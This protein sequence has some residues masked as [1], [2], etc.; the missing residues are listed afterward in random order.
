M[1]EKLKL[2]L[3]SLLVRLKGLFGRKHKAQDVSDVASEKGEGLQS[4]TLKAEDVTAAQIPLW[5]RYVKWYVVAVVVIVVLVLGFVLFSGGAK[6][7]KTESAKLVDHGLLLQAQ[8]ETKELKGR[9]KKLY[10]SSKGQK[11]EHEALLKSKEEAEVKAKAALEAFKEHK[12]A[13]ESQRV[14]V[15]LMPLGANT[16]E[17]AYSEA[18]RLLKAGK[19]EAVLAYGNSLS[20]YDSDM[21]KYV[22]ESSVLYLT[23][24]NQLQLARLM[25][26]NLMAHYPDT[27]KYR[28]VLARIYLLLGEGNKGVT[29]LTQQLPA[30][31]QHSAYYAVLAASYMQASRFYEAQGIY[32]EL[33]AVDPGNANFWLGIAIVQEHLGRLSAA[34]TSYE[35]AVTDA[36]PGWPGV[37]FIEKRLDKFVL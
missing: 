23:Q 9:L 13:L 21:Y 29:L 33:I 34:H 3:A 28:I 6:K 35:N 4:G 24:S 32:Q 7:V 15:R 5:R 10:R 37:G 14:K 12:K 25:V 27:L 30:I 11:K 2:I 17:G 1:V 26:V 19:I 22:F 20:A 8:K 31:G 18:L 16:K 36:E